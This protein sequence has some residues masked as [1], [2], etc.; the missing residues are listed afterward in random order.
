MRAP[1]NAIKRPR[2]E[3]LTVED[4]KVKLA[5]AKVFSILDMNE[6]YHQIELEESSR[7]MTTFYGT[8]G[9]LRYKRLNFGSISSQD[10]FDKAMDDTIQGLKGVLHIRD[11]FIIYGE[12][13]KEHGV[14]LIAF[15]NR[16][17]ECGL[18][19][20]ARKCKIGVPEIEFF[21]M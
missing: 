9:R 21:G 6:A 15:L 4:V 13:Q 2:R 12:D 16:F 19:L 20:S 17:K 18:T 11:D 7:H 3:S 10:I 1:N 14:A 5:H 8:D